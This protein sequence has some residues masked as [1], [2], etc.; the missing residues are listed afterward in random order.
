MNPA[1]TSIMR[2]DH[3]TSLRI[4]TACEFSAVR[5][6]TAKVRDWLA[7]KGLSEAELDDWAIVLVEAANNAVKYAGH[8]AHELPVVIEIFWGEREIEAQITDHTSGFDWPEVVGLPNLES[9]NGRGLFLIKS[10]TDSAA[11]LRHCDHNVLVLRRRTRPVAGEA[12]VMDAAQL[13]CRLANAEA[14][15]SEMT[16]ELGSSYESLVAM[17]RY[18][19]ELGARL[20]VKDFSQRL[21]RDLMQIAE[22]DWAVLRLAS[23]DGKILETLLAL[24]DTGRSLL[25]PLALASGNTSVE[26]D[27][28]R[29]RQD[30][31][32][33]SAAP[34]AQGDPLS[35]FNNSLGGLM[36]PGI[37][38]CHA[39]HVADQLVGTATLG[40]LTANRPF[41]AAQVNLLHTFIDFL[42][43][44]IVNSRL[45][46]ERTATQVIQHE[47]HIAANIQRS[48]LPETIPACLPF[49]LTAAC[50][51]ASQ[52]GGDFYD[53]I[54]AGD[55][56][57]LLVIADVMG[58]GVPA[59]LFAAVL[60]STIRS[61]P[62]LFDQP[63]ELLAAAN[64]TL[65]PDL[66]KV[67][68]FVTAQVAYL[69]PQQ[70]KLISANAGHCPL[71]LWRAD[72]PQTVALSESGFPL[73]IE[74]LSR[75]AQIETAL[76][77]GAA[78]LLY[79]DGLSESR[80]GA[81]AMLGERGML[82]ILAE[83]AAQT[84]DAAA[85][86][87]FLLGHLAAY[88]G[89]SP[90]ADDQTLILIRHNS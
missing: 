7:Q 62:Q 83:T 57:W 29:N 21:L 14:T 13:Q 9:E 2:F 27:A 22:A 51:S 61:M 88:C 63:G 72:Q 6:A 31:W 20:D 19:S 37:G 76:P 54:P 53:I 52:V 55:G 69:N 81:G 36:P 49:T 39:F 89:Q 8:E 43:I 25:P 38:I 24:P 85:G 18:S 64:R 47:L 90:L 82:Q 67:D 15:L 11:Y 73:G 74:P 23:P 40:R 80:N 48:L 5:T 26:I 77:P 50:Q 68:M 41:I 28:V 17:F 75:Y 66:T 71:L 60:R 12:Q 33:D 84:H 59:A 1:T 79:T 87:F 10:L 4:E 44:Q 65:F 45:L 46:D 42:A 78:A 70:H 58:K 32:F 34:L 30:I 3:R 16:A 56:A 35:V 86:K